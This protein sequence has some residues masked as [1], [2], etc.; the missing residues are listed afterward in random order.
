MVSFSELKTVKDVHEPLK[1]AA[2]RIYQSIFPECKIENLRAD[3]F[4]VHVLDKEFGI[5]SLIHFKSNQW[6]S[7]QEK[8]RNYPYW[9]SYHDFTQE[10]ENGDGSQGEW[11][12]L[13]AQLYFYGWG[14]PDKDCFLEWYIFDVAKYKTIIESMGGIQSAGVVRKNNK[15]GKSRFVCVEISA[16]KSA[17]LFFG[18]GTTWMERIDNVVFSEPKPLLRSF[19]N[20]DDQPC[21]CF[22]SKENRIEI[23]PCKATTFVCK[24]C[25]FN[26]HENGWASCQQYQTK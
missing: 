12:K 26:H 23:C 1:P 22:V 10:I 18:T 15:H 13:G 2:A 6:I 8:Y 21:Q 7:I 14:A 19:L 17:V 3:G 16:I 4:K 5:D 24:N 20:G 25:G 9:K 11:F